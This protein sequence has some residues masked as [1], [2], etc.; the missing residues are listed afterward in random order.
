MLAR[1]T[2]NLFA[3]KGTPKIH[4]TLSE[5]LYWIAGSSPAITMS[6][7]KKPRRK[8]RGFLHNDRDE[9]IEAFRSWQ[10]WQRPTLPSL[11]T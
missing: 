6:K 3:R 5:K 10:A 11:E 1:M 8:P 7:N 2:D 9:E 4:A